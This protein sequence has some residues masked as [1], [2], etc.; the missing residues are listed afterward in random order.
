MPA[1]LRAQ[2][3]LGSPIMHVRCPH[4]KNPIELVDLPPP[5]EITCAG[6][7]SSF[8]LDE[9][10]TTAWDQYTGK[11]FGKFLV[12]GTVGHGAFGTVLKARDPELDRTVALKI[13]RAGNVGHGP[14]DLDRFLREAR[15]V[16]QLRFP[17]I[18]TVLEVGTDQGTPYL[19]SDFV[20]GVTLADQLTA[21]RLTFAEAAGLI[22]AVADALDYAHS[23]GVVHRDVK[24]SNIMIRPDGSPCVMDFGLA[25]RAA[26]EV[27][28]TIDGQVLGTPAYM[29]PE[30]A[31]GEGH[32]V[33]GKSDVYSLGVILYQLLTGELPFRGNKAML[34]HQVLHDEPK[35][36]R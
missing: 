19:V 11:R 3:Q 8:R 23:L 22:A 15:S 24:P 21:R 20:E 27:T 7:G 34:L 1:D 16:A 33:D 29:S 12:V 36:P 17:S 25:K 18:I 32:R 14:Q 30:Q 31:R 28:M 2:W 13:P 9:L 4:C 35:P 5:G 26:G 10:P 6:C